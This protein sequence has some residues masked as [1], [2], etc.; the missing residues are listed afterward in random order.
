[1]TLLFSL[2]PLSPHFEPPQRTTAVP[3][4]E[5]VFA[6]NHKQTQRKCACALKTL[7]LYCNSQQLPGRGRCRCYKTYVNLDHRPSGHMF[8]KQLPGHREGTCIKTYVIV[9]PHLSRHRFYK[10]LPGQLMVI[11]V[12]E[13]I[14]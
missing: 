1:M 10:Q 8:C 11:I 14:W 2:K 12:R 5:L 9:E 3:S 6:C 13:L 7:L 4:V